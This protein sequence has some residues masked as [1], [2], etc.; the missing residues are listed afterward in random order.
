[1]NN[2]NS[3]R[4]VFRRAYLDGRTAAFAGRK[5]SACPYEDKLN[6]RGHVTFSR[7][8]RNAW[9]AGW[10]DAQEDLTSSSR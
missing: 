7:A 1:M 3:F 9:S 10:E 5:E 6:W 8:F 4:R 2:S